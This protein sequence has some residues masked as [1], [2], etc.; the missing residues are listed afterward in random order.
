MSTTKKQEKD[1]LLEIQNLKTY[2]PIKGG[3]FKKTIGNVKAVDDVSFTI[4]NGET[5]GLVGESG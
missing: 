3:F 1:N 5:L 2:Y 4:K